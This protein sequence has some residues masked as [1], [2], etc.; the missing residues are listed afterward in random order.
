MEWLFI[1]AP[2]IVVLGAIL[3]T[4]DNEEIRN[5]A[6]VGAILIIVC[7]CTIAAFSASSESS[8]TRDS[9]YFSEYVT[10][11]EYYEPWNE[12]IH[13]MCTR[14][15]PCGSDS[16]GNVRYCTEVYDCSYVKNHSAKYVM[17]TNCG[18][19][20]ISKEKYYALVGQFKNQSFKD[21]HRDYHTKDGDKYYSV[22]PGDF[23]K[24]EY[25]VSKHTY[26]N[27]VQASEDV[28]NFPDVLP[29]EVK[30][31][32][33]YEYPKIQKF[34]QRSIIGYDD[35]KL[36]LYLNKKNALIGKSKE[37]RVFF[38][39]YDNQPKDAAFMQKAYWKGGNKNEFIVC[40]G[41]S[42]NKVQWC[43]PITWSESTKCISK[44]RNY[45]MSN[46]SFN[47]KQYIDYT[48]STIKSD[49]KRKQFSDFDYIKIYMTT[50]SLLWCLGVII[51][52]CI[53]YIITIWHIKNNKR[54]Y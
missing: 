35:P 50:N 43:E 46:D 47:L 48:H 10:S 8:R 12:Y 40:L 44:V 3:S 18:L 11:V 52:L 23:D 42:G 16:K 53:G 1:I 45:V 41:K 34:K 17:I 25:V 28:F 15:Y 22:F 49:F 27:R 21:M 36:D 2:I 54:Y 26:E 30:E 24:L 5:R 13:Q 31:Y 9:E 33:L 38:V 32:G 51:F 7:L 20:G 37:V 39:V 19:Y 6:G 14:S 29:E 4:K